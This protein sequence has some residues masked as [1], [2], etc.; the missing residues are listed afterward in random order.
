MTDALRA[1]IITA[2]E[3]TGPAAAMRV[4]RLALTLATEALPAEPDDV[5]AIETVIALDDALTA[6]GDLRQRTPALLAAADSG[7][8]V[9]GYL[10]DRLAELTGLTEQ[11]GA[12]RAALTVMRQTE[13][14]V[15]ARLAELAELRLEVARLRRQEMLARALTELDAQRAELTARADTLQ[16]Q[17]I[18]IEDGVRLESTNLIRLSH[19]N[20][21]ALAE[22]VR[23]ALSAAAAAE[24]ARTAAVTELAE[25]EA[26]SAAARTELQQAMARSAELRAEQDDRL[27]AL[28]AHTEANQR[29]TEALQLHQ[30]GATETSVLTGLQTLLAETAARLSEIDTALAGVLDDRDVRHRRE[31]TVR[32]WTGR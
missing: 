1:E 23:E 4:L 16:N 6:S 5:T 26:R 22:P 21:A 17:T 20:L 28:A 8:A 10:R 2:V 32:A 19:E 9:D 18:N 27:A 14:D 3:Q 24:D 13:K 29:I 31:H 25:A 11:V 12:A 7:P 15:G 30:P